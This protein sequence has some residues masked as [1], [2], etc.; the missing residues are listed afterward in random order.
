[1]PHCIEL[2]PAAPSLMLIFKDVASV[3]A[4]A[5]NAAEAT[6]AQDVPHGAAISA[7]CSRNAAHLNS[8]RYRVPHFLRSLTHLPTQGHLLIS[9]NSEDFISF[10][11]FK[12]FPFLKD[13]FQYMTLYSFDFFFS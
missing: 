4:A 10:Y 5:D 6:A 1:M 13:I 12:F 3:A 7:L 8:G 2:D 9:S 11:V